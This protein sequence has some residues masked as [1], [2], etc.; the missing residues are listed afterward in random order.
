MPKRRISALNMELDSGKASRAE[1]PVADVLATVRR[2]G[3]AWSAWEQPVPFGKLPLWQI[4]VMQTGKNAFGYQLLAAVKAAMEEHEAKDLATLES[5]HGIKLFTGAPPQS[6][7]ADPDNVGIQAW[8]PVIYV[9]GE[10]PAEGLKLIKFIVEFKVKRRD[11]PATPALVL[12]QSEHEWSFGF[13]PPGW[14]FRHADTVPGPFEAQPPKGRHHVIMQ[15]ETTGE[16]DEKEYLLSFYGGIY[17]F[18]EHFELKEVTGAR[19]AGGE[20]LRCIKFSWWTSRTRSK[21][22][23][24]L[25]CST[26]FLSTS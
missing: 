11:L 4:Q 19:E 10:T 2:W 25:E 26:T 7:P 23:S 14:V 24:A 16:E 5:K 3:K 12:A 8:R 18:R 15:A 1:P 13:M 17:V 6:T 9:A 20:F 21:M 22:C